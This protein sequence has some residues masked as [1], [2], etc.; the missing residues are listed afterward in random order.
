MFFV[1]FIPPV[2]SVIGGPVDVVQ[3]YSYNDK[4]AMA[5]DDI[6]GDI[7]DQIVVTMVNTCD[8]GTFNVTYNVVDHAGNSADEAT[9][10]VNV[11]P[12]K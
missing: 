11:E 8:A 5:E 10:T 7:T 1:E 9:R 6:D 4:G 12:G 3:H 2:I